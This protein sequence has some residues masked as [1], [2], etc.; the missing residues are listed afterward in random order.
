[1]KAV[2][3]VARNLSPMAD[4]NEKF[5]T[6]VPFTHIHNEPSYNSVVFHFVEAV[7]SL[8]STYTPWENLNYFL[9]EAFS[10]CGTAKKISSHT[11]NSLPYLYIFYI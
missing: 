6:Y 3:S 10:S 8:L 11:S 2:Y 1:M 4:F 7:T 5:S 9:Y